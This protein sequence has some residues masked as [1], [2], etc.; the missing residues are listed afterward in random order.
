VT[1]AL[2]ELFL[3]AWSFGGPPLTDR[4]SPIESLQRAYVEP[5]GVIFGDT[6]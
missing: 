4:G 2:P 1:D 6:Q 3:D 5:L